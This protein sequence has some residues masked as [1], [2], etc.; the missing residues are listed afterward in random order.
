MSLSPCYYYAVRSSVGRRGRK[1]FL[2]GLGWGCCRDDFKV[3]ITFEYDAAAD[4]IEGDVHVDPVSE[5][6]YGPRDGGHY[7]FKSSRVKGC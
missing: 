3:C 7:S 6:D 2:N 5:C 4:S 1:A